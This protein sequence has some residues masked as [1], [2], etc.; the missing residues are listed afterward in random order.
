MCYWLPPGLDGWKVCSQEHISAG[1]VLRANMHQHA[2]F[3]VAEIWPFFKMAAVRHLGFL[4]VRNFTY[5][6]A[7]EGQYASLC[8]I[9]CLLVD[10][11][12]RY[13]RLSIF[14]MAAVRNLGYVLRIFGPIMK[15]ICRSLSL[16]KI[17][18]K[19]VQ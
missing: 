17:W 11:L 15:S 3:R 16:C 1:S 18:L 19:S 4:K 2:K 6:S 9:S 14:K 8:Q 5:Q 12:R 13:G 10:L 7:M